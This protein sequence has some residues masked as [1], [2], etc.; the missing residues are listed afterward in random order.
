[1]TDSTPGRTPDSEPE[2]DSGTP[3]ASAAEPAASGSPTSAAASAAA[4]KPAETHSG[5][6]RFGIPAVAAGVA[7]FIGLA[8]GFGTGFF[9]SH[10]ASGVGH[11][12]S[13]DK[14]QQG[15]RGPGHG[16]DQRENN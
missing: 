8:I 11:H 15:D 4:S 12:M 3:P 5:W 7:L 6:I 2:R 1:M 10:V 14:H 9:A 13:F 16:W